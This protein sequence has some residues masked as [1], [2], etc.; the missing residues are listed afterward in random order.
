M[1]VSSENGTGAEAGTTEETAH[2]L[3]L[4]G[5]LF[6]DLFIFFCVGVLPT[7]VYVDIH[8]V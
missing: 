4:H 2:T 7:F 1:E 6:L 5:L 3:T 8:A